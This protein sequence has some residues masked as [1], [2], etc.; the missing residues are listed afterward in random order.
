MA[1][2]K[3]WVESCLTA[4]E[5]CG[6]AH[7]PDTSKM[8]TASSTLGR[9][10]TTDDV[11]GPTAAGVAHALPAREPRKGSRMSKANSKKISEAPPKSKT[12]RK[13]A[14]EETSDDS[15]A[16][17]DDDDVRN[18]WS[19][20]SSSEDSEGPRDSSENEA[21][22][23]DDDD[24]ALNRL[25]RKKKAIRD[26]RRERKRRKEEQCLEKPSRRS[27]RKSGKE[28]ETMNVDT[29]MDVDAGPGATTSST[30]TGMA[31]GQGDDGGMLALP[32]VEEEAGRVAPTR[33]DVESREA[34]FLWTPPLRHVAVHEQWTM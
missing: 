16:S 21:C 18:G 17:D 5:A 4:E 1:S 10:F 3:E 7:D 24:T 25:K 29:R 20:R 19:G 32:A 27:N 22:D 11:I 9:G 8:Y 2:Y 23:N 15:S 34:S 30:E 26:A 14:G 6:L 28:V 33:D 31:T 13:K 12:L